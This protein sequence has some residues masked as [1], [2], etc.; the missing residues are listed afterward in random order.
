VLDNNIEL[1]A[2][3]LVSEERRVPHKVAPASGAA[4]VEPDALALRTCVNYA[5]YVAD[6]SRVER[7]M[8]AHRSHERK[9]SA[10][11]KLIMTGPFADGSGA[12][13][14]YRAQSKAEG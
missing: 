8:R 5:K 2:A 7:I 11:G 12:L 14:I 13:F 6:R 4:S 10:N 3:A 1:L 9:I